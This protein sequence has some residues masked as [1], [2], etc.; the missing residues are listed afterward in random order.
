[1]AFS[2]FSGVSPVSAIG[3]RRTPQLDAEIDK[4]GGADP[5]QC[6]EDRCRCRKQRAEAKHGGGHRGEITER[7]TRNRRRCKASAMAKRI[8]DDE[9]MV[10]P[11]IARRIADAATNA[12]QCS[13]DMSYAPTCEKSHQSIGFAQL[14]V[15]TFSQQ[16]C[17]KS[18]CRVRQP[19]SRQAKRRYSFLREE[20]TI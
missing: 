20:M 3:D 18:R 10:G 7:N 1:M 6:G 14:Q 5:F 11:G 19:L 9:R 12:S 13:M 2:F 17:I 16:S 4:I 15:E 8:G